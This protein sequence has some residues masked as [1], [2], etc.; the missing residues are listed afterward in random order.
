MPPGF[1][2]PPL[3][4]NFAGGPPP[5][6]L[7]HS[8]IYGMHIL[9][10]RLNRYASSPSRL[11]TTTQRHATGLRAAGSSWFAWQ[12]AALHAAWYASGNASRNAARHA[13]TVPEWLPTSAE[14][15][16]GERNGRTAGYAP[17]DATAGVLSREILCCVKTICC[18]VQ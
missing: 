11:P 5:G 9:T 1:G 12:Y 2:G 7:H 8:Q 13:T 14:S 16:P 6:K 15:W 3:P 18:C 17:W 4:P 10:K